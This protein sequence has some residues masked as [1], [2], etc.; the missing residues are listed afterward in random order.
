MSNGKKQPAM[1]SKIQASIDSNSGPRDSSPASFDVNHEK[2]YVGPY[3]DY[4]S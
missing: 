2:G 1:L 3:D 4:Q